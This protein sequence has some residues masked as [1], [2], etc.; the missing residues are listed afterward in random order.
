MACTYNALQPSEIFCRAPLPGPPC[1]VTAVQKGCIDVE[2]KDG[3]RDSIPFGTCVWATGISMHPLVALLKSKLPEEV[4]TSRRGLL[5][6]DHLRV[7]GTQGTVFC[8]GDA[9]V[10]GATPQACLP[11]TAQ[12]TRQE[13][14]YL[15]ALLS[16]NKLALHVG[17][18]AAAGEDLVPLPKRARPFWCAQITSAACPVPCTPQRLPQTRTPQS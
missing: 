10:T 11:P 7:L 6:D 18:A 3:S 13:G 14:E 15:A 9:A 16:K 5:V 12:V 2:M 4:Q 1:R 17:G 8:L